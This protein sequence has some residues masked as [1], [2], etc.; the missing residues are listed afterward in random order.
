[1][2]GIPRDA[3][4]ARIKRAYRELA[5][6]HHPDQN[7]GDPDAERAFREVSAAYTILSDPEK[8]E[9]YDRRGFAGVDGG[10]GPDLGSFTELFEGV[11]GDLFGRKRERR[12]GRDLR[13]TLELEFEEAALGV[14]R[15]IHFPSR[16]RCAE[17]MGTG[18]NGG[19]RGR[20]PCATCHGK[21]EIKA[22]QG[23][24][25]VTKRCPTCGGGGYVI[26]EP[27][28]RCKGEGSVEIERA[29]EVN[30]PAGVTDGTTRRVAGEGEPGRNGA[31][32]GDLHVFVK[33]KTHP[34]FR[35][36]GD[37]ISCDVPVGL[38]A[39][40]VGGAIEVPTLEGT[41]EMKLPAGTQSGAVFRLRG[42]G[43]VVDGGKRG[44]L[45]MRVIVEVPVGLDDDQRRRVR[46]LDAALTP[47]QRPETE[48]F[49]ARL[50]ELRPKKP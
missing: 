24:F 29:Y 42:K 34:L 44:D 20:K 45:H 36:E 32:H 39:A 28:T 50:S 37:V 40:M 48:R 5:L 41:A 30:I 7:A 13:Y 35:R 14:K 43:A 17:C 2:L 4:A 22:Q 15:T 9:R 26:V 12:Q 38:G 11:F 1:V 19:E 10:A 16:E 23:F 33:V 49:R 47:A 6:R 31:P 18:A 3:D 25:G 27:C 8:R 21:G 46:E